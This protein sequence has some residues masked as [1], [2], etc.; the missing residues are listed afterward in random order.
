MQKQKIE[1]SINHC[2]IVRIWP[3]T[4]RN[5]SGH[6]SL[7]VFCNGEHAYISLWSNDEPT[8]I[9]AEDY[10][11]NRKRLG[12]P[13]LFTNSVS[14]DQLIEGYRHWQPKNKP[15]TARQIL[16]KSQTL[17]D[18]ECNRL[19]KEYGEPSQIIRLYSLNTQLIINKFKEFKHQQYPRWAFFA[20][21]SSSYNQPHNCSS[22]IMNLLNQAGITKLLSPIASYSRYLGAMIGVIAGLYYR[23]LSFSN[24]AL[25]ILCGTGLGSAMGGSYQGLSDIKNFLSIIEIN[26][27]GSVS[28]KLGL[29]LAAM[30]SQALAS[31]IGYDR[32]I[33]DYFTLPEHV[34]QSVSLAQIA[35]EQLFVLTKNEDIEH[36]YVRSH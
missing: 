6:V 28:T 16:L 24:L 13:V 15:L 18:D 23:P 14:D 20:G 33:P 35:E 3:L 8:L 26:D 25:A 34:A 31:T 27:K 19:R 36:H 12:V 30:F 10:Q 21:A 11:K 32:L 29:Q 4:Q 1:F 9:T 7:E 5:H 17:G 22:F 2:V